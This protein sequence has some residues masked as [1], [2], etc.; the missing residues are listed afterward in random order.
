MWTFLAKLI[1]RSLFIALVALL[2]PLAIQNRQ[3]ITLYYDPLAWING[4]ESAGVTLPL[5]LVGWSKRWL[6]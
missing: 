2:I 6:I 1:T 4:S 5:L 3:L